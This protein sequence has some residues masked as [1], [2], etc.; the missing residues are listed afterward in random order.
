MT[1]TTTEAKIAWSLADMS[2]AGL[3]NRSTIWRLQRTDPTF[4]R[5]VA[6]RGIKRWLPDEVRAWVKQQPR[7]GIA[8]SAAG[9]DSADA[10]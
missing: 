2:A 10:A 7:A 5:P 6:I 9:S 8:K 4:P 3:G 1:T